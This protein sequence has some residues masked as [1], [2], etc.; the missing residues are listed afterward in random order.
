MGELQIATDFCNGIPLDDGNLSPPVYTQP[1][2]NSQIYD[3]AAASFDTAMT[4]ASGTDAASLNINRAARI[5]KARS[6]LGN[7]KFSDAA[8]LVS[9]ASVPTT[10]AYNFTFATTSGNNPIWTINP[11]G[12]TYG[13]AD[14]VEGNS[15]NLI[16]PYVIP[17]FSAHDPRLPVAYTVSGKDTTKGA[18]GI[19]LHRA[20]TLYGQ[21][22]PIAMV[23]GIDARLVEAEARLQASDIPGMMTILNA[24]RA[25]TL[26]IGTVTV[27]SAQLPPLAVPATTDAA[28]SLL[29]R[30]KAFWTFSRGL[31]LGDMRRL[32]RQYGRSP[33]TVY[34]TGPYFTGG[35][36]YATDVNLPLGPDENGNPFFKGCTDLKA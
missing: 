7:A 22:T 11:S 34:P 20:T 31:R 27:T 35:S 8:A 21:T 2:S 6:L 28:V 29:F 19:T 10:Y 36:T 15:R 26:T 24:L 23:N 5:G 12:R 3:V 14:S 1:L 13:V 4:L 9:T 33:D 32:V 16:V 17:Y 30:E 25:T 18:D